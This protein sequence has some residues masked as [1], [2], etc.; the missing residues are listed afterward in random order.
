M[1]V[2]WIQTTFLLVLLVMPQP[3]SSYSVSRMWLCGTELVNALNFVC[4]ERRF[5]TPVQD[6]RARNKE[7][8]RQRTIF[9]KCC[10]ESCSLSDLE[11]YCP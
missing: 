11:Q 4:G 7:W 1:A 9:R 10:E 6:H 2:L 3:S 8:E 5:G